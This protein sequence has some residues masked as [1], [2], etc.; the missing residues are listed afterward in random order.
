MELSADTAGKEIAERG[1]LAEQKS[2]TVLHD[3]IS[4]RQRREDDV[5]FRHVP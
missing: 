5:G 1:K 3:P 4:L 2:R